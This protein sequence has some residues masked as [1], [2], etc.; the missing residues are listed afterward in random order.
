[1]KRLVVG[2]WKM[3]ETRQ[4]GATLARAIVDALG[5]AD[6]PKVTVVLAPPFTALSAVASVLNGTRIELGAQNMHWGERGA[7]T[8]E[9]S[10]EMLTDLGV[11]YVI[12]GHSERRR[13]FHESDSDVNKKTKAALSHNLI[14]I[15]AVGETEDDRDA[16]LTD[17]RVTSQI[18]AGLEGIVD[19]QLRGIVIAYE[20]VWAIGTGRNCEPPEAERVMSVIRG[21]IPGLRDVPILYGGSVTPKNFA[22]YLEGKQCAGGLVGGASL[23]SESFV[24]LVNIAYVAP[25]A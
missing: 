5:D 20:P 2:N 10:A 1:V 25:R 19:E 14:P 24:E 8:G 16:G 21:S 18:R 22:S 12:V 4:S 13:Y 15:V 9:I 11:S 3:H 23:R 6:T 7:F 17:E